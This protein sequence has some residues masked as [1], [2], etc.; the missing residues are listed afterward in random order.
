MALEARI[1]LI[2][3][4]LYPLSEEAPKRM[5]TGDPPEHLAR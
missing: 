1:C 3:Y 4:F 2:C 5:R